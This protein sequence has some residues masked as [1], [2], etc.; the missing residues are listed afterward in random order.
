V[1]QASKIPG[2]QIVK[3]IKRAARKHYSSDQKIRIVLD[4]LRG[5]GCIA[6]LCR[7]DGISR[8][9]ITKGPGTVEANAVGSSEP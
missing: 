2:E 3:D 7:C 1:R 4:S 5:A 9:A 8:G 6:E